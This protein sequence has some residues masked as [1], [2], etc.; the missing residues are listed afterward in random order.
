MCFFGPLTMVASCR[1][2]FADDVV[3]GWKREVCFR[4]RDIQ[5]EVGCKIATVR[6]C[7]VTSQPDCQP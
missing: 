3:E 2:S 6:V 4:G 1:Q 7:H 5:M